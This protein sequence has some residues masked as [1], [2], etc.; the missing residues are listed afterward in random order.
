MFTPQLLLYGLAVLC[1]VICLPGLVNPKRYRKE[2]IRMAKD[3]TTVRIYGMFALV[4]GFLFL[5][6]Q[7]KF[8]NGKNWM[9]IIP[10][11]GWLSILKGIVYNW[12]PEFVKHKI[13][14]FF[15]DDSKVT[16]WSV[17]GT[18]LAVALAYVAMNYI[19]LGEMVSG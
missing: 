6:V 8:D 2:M 3:E 10:I 18:I 12:S 13:K 19:S 7:W 4:I 17:L 14:M 1:L 16:L 11:I 15:G 9:M 5:S